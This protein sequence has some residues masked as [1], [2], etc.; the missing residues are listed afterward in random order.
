MAG[1]DWYKGKVVDIIDETYN[2]KRFFVEL[3]ELERAKFLPGQYVQIDFPIESSKTYR[4][5]SIASPPNGDNTIELLIVLDP[6]GMATNYLFKE[7]DH[8]SELIISR[9]MGNFV[10]P[11]KLENDVCF[12]STGTGLAPLRSMYLDLL[13]RG[14]PGQKVN[15]VVGTRYKK[16][17]IYMDEI[18]ELE[19][20]YPNFN[21]YPV[22]SR[23]DDPSWKGRKGYVH[24]VYKELYQEGHPA[25]FFI[26]GWRNMVREARQNLMK[27]GYHRRDI[28][29]ERYN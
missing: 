17:L 29:F 23:E 5:Y 15:L 6:E 12:I 13:K 26:C 9:F 25:Q 11:E 3:P 2:I 7:I 24:E 21:F 28:H 19:Q 27:M 1:M 20:Q 4:Q 18:K 16:D 8:G 14:N 22:L 10:L